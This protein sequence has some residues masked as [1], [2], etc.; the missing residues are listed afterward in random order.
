MTYLILGLLVI[1]SGLFSG[2]NLGLMSLDPYELKRKISLGDWR[3]K[4][5]YPI[6]KQGNLLLVTLLLCNVAVNAAISL[7]LGSITSGVIAGVVSTMI[8][9]VFGEIV[10]QAA[11]SR[12]ALEVGARSIPLVRLFIL[13]TYPVAKPMA[14]ALDKV[15]GR[16][17]PTIYSKA[18]LVKII[19]EHGDAYNSDLEE[20]EEEL[21]TNALL[22]ADKTVGQIMTHRDQIVAVESRTKLT[23]RAINKIV[24]TGHSRIL[25]Y[26]RTLDHVIGMLFIKELVLQTGNQT[27]AGR[28][29]HRS[30][31][32]TSPMTRLHTVL[33]KFIKNKRHLFVVKSRGKTVGVISIE[34]VIEE[35]L[36]REI[37]DEHDMK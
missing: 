13:F 11:F 9:T 37:M 4:R 34:D 2:L 22:F 14:W 10:P 18:E 20:H 36:G 32:T 5:I 26:H 8:I 3:A 25:V 17:L 15:L 1:L 21:A 33:R 28:I 24:S 19:E 29:C 12:F 16:E 35:I 27:T 6:R 7:L 31:V 23:R 30:V